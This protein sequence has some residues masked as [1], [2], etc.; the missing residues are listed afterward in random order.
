[1]KTKVEKTD[2]VHRTIEVELPWDMIADEMDKEYRDLAKKVSIKGFRK[3][4]V[5]LSYIMKNYGDMMHSDAVRNLLPVIYE[6]ALEREGID[7][8]SNPRFEN[9]SAEKGK[10]ITVDIHIEVRPEIQI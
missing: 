8:V 6:K 10:G 3:G 1:M 5:P 9:M 4:K 2:Q 7:P